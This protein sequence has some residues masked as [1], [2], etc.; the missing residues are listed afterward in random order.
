MK[1]HK[2]I[3]KMIQILLIIISIQ[4]LFSHIVQAHSMGDI[5]DGA[6]NFLETGEAL[7]NNVIP[8]ASIIAVSNMLYNV[9][10]SIG[11]VAAVVMSGFLGIKYMTGGVEEQVKV[12]ESLLPFII[13]CAVVFGAFTLWKLT[14]MLLQQI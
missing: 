4:F 13:G 14:V 1:L 8:E 5:I 7:S 12:K 3:I 2:K 10:L 9:L 6:K 11:I